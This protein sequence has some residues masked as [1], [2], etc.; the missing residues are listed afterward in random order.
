MFD[1]DDDFDH[2]DSD[3]EWSGWHLPLLIISGFTTTIKFHY[4]D[5]RERVTLDRVVA[6]DH[7]LGDNPDRPTHFGG[8]C[9]KRREPRTFCISSASMVRTMDDTPIRDLAAFLMVEAD[10]Q[11]FQAKRRGPL[12]WKEARTQRGMVRRSMTGDMVYPHNRTDD[13]WGGDLMRHAQEDD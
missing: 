4:C 5:T 8:R 3:R 2:H 6:V 1:D 11:W 13:W 10:K 12:S 7:L 9:R